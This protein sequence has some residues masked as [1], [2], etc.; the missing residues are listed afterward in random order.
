MTKEEVVAEAN[1]RCNQENLI[2]QLKGDVRALHSPLNTLEANWAYMVMAALAW[3]LK[4]WF[5]LLLPTCPRWANKHDAQR[6]HV[7]RMDFRTFLNN[8]MLVPVQVI[9]TG[10][11]LIFRLLAWR[12]QLHIMVRLLN[13]I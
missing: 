7:L 1:Q 8:F 6:E 10:H 13:A 9:R 3:N 4:A 12:P 2:A 11:R 5:A